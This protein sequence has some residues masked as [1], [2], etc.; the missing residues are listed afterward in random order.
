[1]VV[2]H[3]N[4]YFPV[5]CSTYCT[6]SVDATTGVLGFDD[7]RSEHRTPMA[8]PGREARGHALS[9]M[10][11]V[12]NIPVQRMTDQHVSRD[13]DTAPSERE[14]RA[15]SGTAQTGAGSPGGQNS[16]TERVAQLEQQ[17]L[18]QTTTQPQPTHAPAASAACKILP[19]PRQAHPVFPCPQCPL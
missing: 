14:L 13:H 17:T 10:D 8:G 2:N 16:V 4:I 11:T 7:V 3:P 9:T 6:H 15:T 18:Y 1:M 5:L 19:A 12:P